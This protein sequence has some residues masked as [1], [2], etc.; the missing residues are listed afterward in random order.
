MKKFSFRNSPIPKNYHTNRKFC[1]INQLFGANKSALFYGPKGHQ[2]IDFKT[3][4]IFMWMYHRVES[5]ARKINWI[6]WGQIPILVAHNGYWDMDYNDDERDGVYVKV[7]SE[8]FDEDGVPT[9]YQTLYFHLSKIVSW[10]NDDKETVREKTIGPNYVAG[11]SL[12]GYG[13]N[14]GKYTTGPHLHFELR[15]R[16]KKRGQWSIWTKIDPMPYFMDETVY[17]QGI[18]RPKY[19]YKGKQITKSEAKALKI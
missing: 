19:F 4:F 17:Q 12:A 2:G 1:F 3:T 9:Q 7:T 14:S 15:Q 13:G 16:I 8:E 6:R 11:G 18:F 5:Y 10:K